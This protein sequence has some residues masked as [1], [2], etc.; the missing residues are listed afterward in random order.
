MILSYSH[1]ARLVL[2]LRA[3]ELSLAVIMYWV[4]SL[5]AKDKI[6]RWIFSHSLIIKRVLILRIGLRGK[7][8][9]K[10]GC[11]NP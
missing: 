11:R 8:A 10:V 5:I 7:S 3:Y 2:F 9:Y 6:M 1:K 4:V